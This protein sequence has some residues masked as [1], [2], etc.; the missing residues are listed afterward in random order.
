[1]NANR[2]LPHSAQKPCRRAVSEQLGGSIAFVFPEKFMERSRLP[3]F[4]PSAKAIPI[5]ENQDAA[6]QQQ[7]IEKPQR[8]YRRRIEITVQQRDRRFM[9]R[10]FGF[11]IRGERLRVETLD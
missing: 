9:H 4:I 1:M 2:P 3:L 6:I 7:A 8:F 10:E 11:G 5:V